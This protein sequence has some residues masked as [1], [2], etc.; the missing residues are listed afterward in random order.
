MEE[1]T[2]LPKKLSKKSPTVDKTAAVAAAK[3]VLK[4][5][6]VPHDRIN[7]KK[8]KPETLAAINENSSSNKGIKLIPAKPRRKFRFC[9]KLYCDHCID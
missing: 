3:S 8:L 6:S 9:L 4:L 7:E 2:P 5:N 1:E